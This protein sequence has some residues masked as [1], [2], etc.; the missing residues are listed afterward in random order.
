MLTYSLTPSEKR[1]YNETMNSEK[2]SGILT[3]AL[4]ESIALYQNIMNDPHIQETVS[5]VATEIIV[6]F[7]EGGR[8]LIAGN[9]GSAADA[10]HFAGEFQGHYKKDRASLPAIALNTDTST[11]TAIG[12]DYSFHDVFSRQVHSLGQA[13]DIFLAFSTS[14]NSKNILHALETAN[15]K[16]MVTVSFLGKDGGAAKELSDYAIV[17]PSDNTPRIQEVHTLFL[18]EITEEVEKHF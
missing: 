1:A 5:D 11:L 7:K 17:V 9:G 15:E 18:H 10:Q 14:G 16:G 6:R 2:K 4:Q 13:D 8:L 12:N 3:P